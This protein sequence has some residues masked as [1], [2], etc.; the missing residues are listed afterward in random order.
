MENW[1]FDLNAPVENEGD[2]NNGADE[3]EE[4]LDRGMPQL[5]PEYAAETSS[6]GQRRNKRRTAT[7][8]NIYAEMLRHNQRM[9]ELQTEMMQTI[10]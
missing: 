8:E 6:R 3:V 5:P 7:M 2:P 1:I 10:Q 4:E 9:E